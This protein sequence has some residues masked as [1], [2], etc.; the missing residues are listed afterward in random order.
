MTQYTTITRKIEVHLHKHGEGEEA[1]KRRKDEFAIWNEINDNLYKAAN[2]IVSHCF[3]NDAYQYRLQIQS[4]RLQAINKQLK[5]M[6]AAKRPESEMKDLKSERNRLFAEFKEQ[7]FTFLRGGVTEGRNPEQNSTYKVISHE[8]LN[9]IPSNVLT[10][11]NQNISSTY[12]N[13]RK[14]IEFGTRTIPNFKRGIPVP[15]SMHLKSVLGINKRDDGTIYVKFPKGLEWDMHFGSDKSNNREIVERILSGQ[16]AA[17]DSAIQQKRG[18]IFLLLVV[19]IPKKSVVLNPERI[20]GVDLGINTPLYAALNDD[21]HAKLAIGSRDEFLKIRRLFDRRR[22]DLQTSL[23]SSTRGGHGR[24]HKLQALERLGEKERNWVCLQNH[25]F[26]K[27]LVEFA[28][29]NGA[30]VIQMERLT[31]F[32]RTSDGAAADSKKFILRYWSF[33]ELQ[34][35]IEYKARAAGIEVRYVDPYHT[36]QTCSFCGHYEAGQ[37]ISQ[38]HF[39]CKNPEC[40]KGKGRM[41]NGDYTGINA[42]WNAAR[43]IAMSNKIVDRKKK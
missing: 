16:Y 39:I 35:F 20:V 33:F 40:K 14:E 25:N 11:L 7:R 13:Y 34:Q 36:S 38:K 22:R 26:S 42:D 29:K 2:R 1:D 21:E 19:K 43:N 9:V 3:F 10:C 4:P 6:K 28:K 17:G 24:T 27:A 31:G 30:G 37:R 12:K 23:T 18:K 5:N 8:F 32:G 41:Q 15:F